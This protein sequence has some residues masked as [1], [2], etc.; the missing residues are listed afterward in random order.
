MLESVNRYHILGFQIDR[1]RDAA[2]HGVAGS[3][4]AR[5]AAVEVLHWNPRTATN[6]M[7]PS[8]P[9]KSPKQ[10]D[11][12]PDD[13]QLRQEA[14]PNC[15]NHC[16]KGH[17]PH[18][19]RSTTEGVQTETVHVLGMQGPVLP[20]HEEARVQAELQRPD[21]HGVLEEAPLLRLHG[22]MVGQVLQAPAHLKSSH[23]T[24]ASVG[25]RAIG[26][27]STVCESNPAGR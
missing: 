5:K 8:S 18:E 14:C 7:K 4:P 6:N 20:V 12:A 9:P 2:R 26:V 1:A 24:Q 22:K 27:R 16:A 3:E 10:R 21:L 13:T 25:R 23:A 11:M 15:D 19:H 17:R